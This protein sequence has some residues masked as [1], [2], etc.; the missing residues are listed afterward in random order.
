MAY[1]PGNHESSS[2][3]CRFGMARMRNVFWLC[4]TQRCKRHGCVG[5]AVLMAFY[6]YIISCTNEERG[7]HVVPSGLLLMKY[8][9]RTSK[10]VMLV[11]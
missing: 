9:A 8:P 2:M 3:H 6:V 1:C 7:N 4:V 10:R 5:C 11:I